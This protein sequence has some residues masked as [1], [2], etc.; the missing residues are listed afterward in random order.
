MSEFPNWLPQRMSVEG[1]FD[2]IVSRLYNIFHRDF[3]QN[4]PKLDGWDVWY[5]KKVIPGQMYEEV[6]WHLIERDQD[7]QGSRSFDSRRAERLPWCAPVINHSGQ[8]QVKYWICIENRRP[9]CYLWLEEFDYVIIL[10]KRILPSKTI[11]GVE[12][13]ARTIAFLKTAYHI[14]GESKRRHLRRKY[15]E[16]IS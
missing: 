1:S 5:D 12:K 9:I 2:E 13:P 10:E 6:F 7:N 8:P 11:A 4:H 15:G 14:D 3:I 16:K